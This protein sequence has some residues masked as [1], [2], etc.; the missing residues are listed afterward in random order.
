R[1]KAGPVFTFG[2]DGYEE[3]EGAHV[4][5][6]LPREQRDRHGHTIAY[7]WDTSDGHALLVRVTWNAFDAAST[8]EVLLSYEPRPDPHVSF[9]NGI[10]EAFVRRLSAV[11]V[12]HGGVL[13]RRYDLS[14]GD[15]THPT[16][17]SV[18]LVG[19]DGLT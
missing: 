4:A 10:R 7:D 2:G 13:V 19:R 18:T 6:Y 12:R 15:E 5:A 1:T 16:L 3:A 8:N 9:S 17:R 11:T 14:Y